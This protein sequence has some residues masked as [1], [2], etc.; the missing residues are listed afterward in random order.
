MRNLKI[1]A[2][3]LASI[4]CLLEAATGLYDTLLTRQLPQPYP[5]LLFQTRLLHGTEY[6]DQRLLGLAE[7]N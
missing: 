3:A 1:S 6:C 2:I 4:L 7:E 5:A